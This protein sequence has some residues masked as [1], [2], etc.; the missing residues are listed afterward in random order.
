MAQ[1]PSRVALRQDLVIP[2][3]VLEGFCKSD[4]LLNY[5]KDSRDCRETQKIFAKYVDKSRREQ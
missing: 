4:R 5:I 2:G 1:Q 3:N